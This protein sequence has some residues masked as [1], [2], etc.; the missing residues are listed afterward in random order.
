[1]LNKQSL[2]HK[3]YLRLNRRLKELYTLKRKLPLIELDKPYQAGW[4][5]YNDFRDDIKRRLDFPRIKEAVNLVSV[6]VYTRNKQAIK[7]IR[8]GILKYSFVRF[9]NYHLINK[10]VVYPRIK[11]I[12]RSAIPDYLIK[13]FTLD[14]ISR[15]NN[16]QR[17]H[18]Q[19]LMYYLNIPHYW[20]VKKVKPYMITHTSIN[21]YESEI[22]EII[23]QMSSPKYSKFNKG[24]YRSSY[25]YK[26]TGGRHRT[27]ER[28]L[29]RHYINGDIEDIVFS[30]K[31]IDW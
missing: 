12:P 9:N 13:F 16:F 3:E 17:V 8:V 18:K 24:F 19:S 2:Y 4:L 22:H 31:E 25:R 1:M 7:N 26:Y 30:C 20:L 11:D 21:I 23:R 10:N 15:T 6:P 5:V 27:E 29:I 28:D 14:T